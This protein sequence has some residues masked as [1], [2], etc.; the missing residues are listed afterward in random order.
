MGD[1][2]L[3]ISIR[4]C[5]SHADGLSLPSSSSD[6]ATGNL[7]PANV[8][9]NCSMV[10]VA[11]PFIASAK[12]SARRATARVVWPRTAHADCGGHVIFRQE[13]EPITS[14]PCG[15][16]AGLGPRAASAPAT[17]PSCSAVD[18]L[19]NQPA[20]WA[21]PNHRC[22]S[23]WAVASTATRCA[24]R[25]WSARWTRERPRKGQRGIIRRD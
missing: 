16:E 22:T 11:A 6:S 19:Q 14:E 17:R 7:R 9:I 20:S 13:H 10:L 15:G 24:R 3:N 1:V 12:A 2:P 4:R 23:S 21:I 25:S 18:S 5:P 8:R